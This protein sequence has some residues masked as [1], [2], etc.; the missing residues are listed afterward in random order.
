MARIDAHGIVADRQWVTP[1]DIVDAATAH[2]RHALEGRTVRVDADVRRG[3]ARSIRAWRPPR[4]RTCWR[5]PRSTRRADQPISVTARA[6]ARRLRGVGHGQ[7][8]GLDPAELDHLFERFYRGR[9]ARQSSFGT[10]MGLAITRGLLAAAGGRVWAENAPGGGRALHDRRSVRDAR[11]QP[12]WNSGMPVRILVVDDEPNILATLAPLLR[13]R[14]YDVSTAMTGRG[15][16]EAVERDNPDL[17][18][19]R[20]RASGHGRRR[21]H[22]AGARRPGDADRRALGARRRRRQGP[23]ARR[24]ARTTT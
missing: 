15:A 2:V 4:S 24:R 18:R 23:R 8:T 13:S 10:G 12:W 20:S 19:A 22:P 6:G 3:G 14:G 17:D 9:T 7:G 1:A 5:T 16:V 21:G 11:A